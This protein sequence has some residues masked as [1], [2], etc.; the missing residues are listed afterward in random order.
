MPR[1]EVDKVM[2]NLVRVSRTCLHGVDRC[3]LVNSWL[4]ERLR[5]RPHYSPFEAMPSSRTEYPMADL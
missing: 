5:L 4:E 1:K 3:F 2:S